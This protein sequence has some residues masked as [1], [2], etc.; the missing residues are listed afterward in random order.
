M[1]DSFALS[2]TLDTDRVEKSER[3]VKRR[4]TETLIGA[5]SPSVMMFWLR[6]KARRP[7]EGRKT[8]SNIDGWMRARLDRWEINEIGGGMQRWFADFT[9]SRA[10]DSVCV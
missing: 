3:R 6:E 9:R 8:H 2:K 1:A 10:K 5:P 7:N 4:K